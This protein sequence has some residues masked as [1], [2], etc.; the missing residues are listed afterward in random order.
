M[1]TRKSLD[2]LWN[3][4]ESNGPAFDIAQVS[5]LPEGARR[6]LGHAIAAGTPLASAVRLRMHGEIKL[7]GWW[8]FS[9]E[10]VIRRDH[11]MIWQA[12]VRMHGLSICGSDRFVDGRGAMKWKLFG[13]L[14]I[15]NASGPDITRSAAGRVSVESVWLPSVLCRDRVA[16]TEAEASRPHAR[17]TAH[18]ETAEIDYLIDE[19]GKLKTV[20]LPRWG[21]PDGAAFRYTHFGAFVEA[22]KRFGGYTIPTR[23]RVGW[24][25]GTERF[26]SEGEFFRVTIDDAVYR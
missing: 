19:Q 26:D 1:S 7:K 9:A 22:E 6:Y 2:D 4:D 5:G 23:M 25:F 15:V 13:I 17:L 18:G 14:P 3:A 8:P 10:Q 16:W 20:S 12:A 24:Y 11:R 21:N